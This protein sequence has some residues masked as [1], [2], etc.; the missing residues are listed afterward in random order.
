MRRMLGLTLFLFA[1]K[2]QTPEP[3]VAATTKPVAPAARK[4][5][6]RSDWNRIAQELDLPFFWASD[7]NTDGTV[8]E[9]EVSLLWGMTDSASATLKQLDDVH[10]RIAAVHEKGHAAA[11]LPEREAKRR[12]LV[13]EELAQGRATLV[14]HDFTKD[15]DQDKAIVKHLAKAAALIERLHAR[16]LGTFALMQELQTTDHAASK[17]LFARNQGPWC[18]APA[19]ESN[20]DCSALPSFPPKVS[21]L[22]PA[23]MQREGFCESM[24]KDKEGSKWLAD[25]FSVIVEND[26]KYQNV[27]YTVAYKEDMEAVAVQLESAAVAIRV[28]EEAPFQEYLRAAAKAFRNNDWPSA[29]EAW[30]KMNV[31]NSRWYLRVGPDEVYF[32]PCGAKAGFHMSFGLIDKGSLKWQSTLDPLK[33]EMEDVLAKLAGPPYKARKVDFHLPDFVDIVL[34]AGDSRS[35]HG[36]TIGQSLPNWGPVANEG[37]GRTVAMTGFYIDADSRAD[38]ETQAKSLFCAETMKSFTTDPGPQLM[39]TVLHEAAHNLGPAHDY[40]AGGKTAPQ[41]FG[42]PLASTM[43]ELKAQTSALFFTDWLVGKGSI[44]DEE[45]RRAHVRDLFWAFGHISRGMYTAD[46]KPKSYSQLAAIQLRNFLAAGAVTWKA[47][48][49]AGNGTDVGCFEVDHA[50]LPSAIEDLMLRVAR[51]KG[52]GDKK[53]AEALV[54][55]FVDAEDEGKKL[56]AVITERV[57]R[58]PK[59]SFVYSVKY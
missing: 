5:V 44:K 35:A 19:T 31:N 52:R 11:D 13:L 51:I 38:Q 1:C 33:Q 29:D 50:K 59:A 3:P 15:P 28:V 27:P 25:H 58:A 16:Q 26:G 4:G 34:N 53:G 43:E 54:K 39:S 14:A 36:A 47:D 20:P 32:E 2:D 46:N 12:K 55:E 18:E 48:E 22:Y 24:A 17:A 41:V 21:G 49:K 45:R 57:L 56:M 8:D 6:P 7:T 40:K 30:S 10:A 42:G 23:A 9:P 37:R